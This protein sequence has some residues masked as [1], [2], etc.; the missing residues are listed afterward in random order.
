MIVTGANDTD[1]DAFGA[2]ADLQ[3]LDDAPVD[4]ELD[5][6]VGRRP[7][8]CDSATPAVTV[9]RSGCPGF[10]RA[11][12]RHRRQRQVRALRAVDHRRRDVVPP[13]KRSVSSGCQPPR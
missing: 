5:R 12:Q 7:S 6:H 4:L 9:T 13:G 1:A 8:R 2:G 11:Q 3:V 10:A